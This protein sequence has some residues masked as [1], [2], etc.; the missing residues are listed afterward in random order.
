MN[1]ANAFTTLWERDGEITGSVG[2]R[3]VTLSE[4]GN[5]VAVATSSQVH[6]FER[7]I[8][9]PGIQTVSVSGDGNSLAHWKFFGGDDGGNV[10]YID[11]W[12]GRLWL[13]IGGKL[14]LCL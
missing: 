13:W 4:A 12:D 3:S 2:Y 8:D 1:P 7:N 14:S 6:V 5:R 9:A 11:R 10:Y